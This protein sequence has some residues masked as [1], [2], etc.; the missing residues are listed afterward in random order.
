M[1]ALITVSLLCI[2]AASCGGGGGGGSGGGS[3]GG[4]SAPPANGPAVG[5]VDWTADIVAADFTQIGLPSPFFANTRYELLLGNATL[6]WTTNFGGCCTNFF[7]PITILAGTP[8]QDRL[9]LA[10]ISQNTLFV[11]ESLVPLGTAL[12][13]GLTGQSL[14]EMQESLE[15]AGGGVFELGKMEQMEQ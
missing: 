5:Y 8:T 3:G 13:E 14:M 12:T 6:F 15:A 11:N 4:G 10:L 9:Y 7:L 1:R 2:L